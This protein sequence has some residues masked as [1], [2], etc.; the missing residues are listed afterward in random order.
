MT[1]SCSVR[2]CKSE[3]YPGCGIKFYRLPKDPNLCSAWKNAIGRENVPQSAAV[4]SKH[5]RARDYLP[6][7]SPLQAKRLKPGSIPARFLPIIPRTPRPRVKVLPECASPD[8]EHYLED[9]LELEESEMYSH[10]QDPLSVESRPVLSVDRNKNSKQLLITI[11]ATSLKSPQEDHNYT[12]QAE[13]AEVTSEPRLQL[14]ESTTESESQDD[15][16][17]ETQTKPPNI[18]NNSNKSIL[19]EYLKKNLGEYERIKWIKEANRRKNR[20]EQLQRKVKVLQNRLRKSKENEEQMKILSRS[21][22]NYTRF[23]EIDN[24][25]SGRFK[26]LCKTVTSNAPKKLDYTP[27]VIKFAISLY[28]LSP[29]AYDFVKKY[30]DLPHTN[31]LQK[32]LSSGTYIINLDE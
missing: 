27:N 4:C 31:I 22:K 5:F 3:S 21:V 25:L 20:I 8:A 1:R 13:P 18:N 30:M 19:Y 17:T 16:E 15:D 11:D 9:S 32:Y 24:I 14:E 29:K 6:R 26:E 2:G 10:Q 28:Y 23:S 7:L 12:L